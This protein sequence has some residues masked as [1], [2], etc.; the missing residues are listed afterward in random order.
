MQPPAPSMGTSPMVP[1]AATS[2]ALMALQTTVTLWT[3]GPLQSKVP[4]ATHLASEPGSLSW[5]SD[6]EL[7]LDPPCPLP[8]LGLQLAV[9]LRAACLLPCMLSPDQA[10]SMLGVDECSGLCHQPPCNLPTQAL[11]LVRASRC[12]W[13]RHRLSQIL[14]RSGSDHCFCQVLCHHLS[15]RPNLP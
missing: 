11:D 3:P 12:G 4:P 5:A 15:L 13:L 9:C 8:W 2:V 14:F 1:T 10:V 7:D 6:R